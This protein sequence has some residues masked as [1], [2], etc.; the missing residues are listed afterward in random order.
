MVA[1]RTHTEIEYIRAS[2]QI[3]FHVQQVLE[4]AIRPG[5]TTLALDQLAETV[6]RD[7]GAV[8]AFKGYRGF[9]NAICASLNA[10]AVHGFP[11]DQPLKTGD[12]LSVDV[13]TR[14]NGYFGDGA[15][16]LGVGELTPKVGR[17][18]ETTRTC[19][20]EGIEQARV[21]K[22][23]S[24]IS[25][26]VQHRAEA[27]GFAVVRGFGGHGIGRA[28]HEEPHI[29]NHGPPGKGPRLRSG[30]V[31]TIEPILSMGS[32]EV[33]IGSDGWTTTTRDGAP[34]AHFEHTLAITDNGPE[35]LTLPVP[36]LAKNKADPVTSG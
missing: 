35:I 27:D 28:L 8:P 34:A 32:R 30:W 4:Q 25:H 21:G 10:Q 1:R 2:C 14:L 20:Y 19:L 6:I 15:F 3:V 18:L 13:G 33:I 12:L 11:N 31:V 5:I 17:L 22:H 16:T 26:A 24:D 36:P 29:P 7:Y 9:P 23:L